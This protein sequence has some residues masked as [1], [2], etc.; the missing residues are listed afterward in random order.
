[1]FATPLHLI[2]TSLSCS[3]TRSV[4]HGLQ[5][6]LLN[7]MKKFCPF[8]EGLLLGHYCLV[9]VFKIECL[10]SHGSV[11]YISIKNIAWRFDVE[12][13]YSSYISDLCLACW[14]ELESESDWDSAGMEFFTFQNLHLQPFTGCSRIILMLI[15][16]LEMFAF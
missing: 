16:W 12:T 2:H 10:H 15:L 13:L 6:V 7:H 14:L 5:D 1:M 9:L 11:F 8:C 3:H 4:W